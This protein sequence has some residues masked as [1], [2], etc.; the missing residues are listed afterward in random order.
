MNIDKKNVLLVLIACLAAYAIFQ[1]QSIKT[2]VA[3]YNVK[4]KSLQKEIDSVSTA[5]KKID[6]QIEKIN[7]HI[8]NV[9]KEINNVTKNINVI[10]NNTDEKVNYITTVG[11]MELERLF[12]N[13]YN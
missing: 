7:S 5:N 10:K 4:I 3:G 1:Y 13:R 6:D 8:I 12:T 9:G 2:D 11:N